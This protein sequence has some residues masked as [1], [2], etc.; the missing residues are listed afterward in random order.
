[1]CKAD[2]YKK[3]EQAV[4]GQSECWSCTH[5][6]TSTVLLAERERDK[7]PNGF[8]NW[9]FMSVHTWGE[10][11]AGTWILR[12]TDMVSMPVCLTSCVWE[13]KQIKWSLITTKHVEEWACSLSKLNE[14]L[15]KTSS[16]VKDYRKKVGSD[17]LV[18]Y[19]HAKQHS[20]FTGLYLG[21]KFHGWFFQ[22]HIS[23]LI[24][25]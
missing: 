14:R 15:L 17:F 1:M 7:S 10:N 2:K 9:D 18:L 25:W 19:L 21:K 22:T 5:T 24:T 3:E 16:W 23:K 11:P 13:L 20:R 8:K 12:I 4:H 6:G